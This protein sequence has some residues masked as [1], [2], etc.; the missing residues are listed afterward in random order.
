MNPYPNTCIWLINGSKQIECLGRQRLWYSLIVVVVVE[1]LARL[2]VMQKI[3]VR[4]Y[5]E[6]ESSTTSG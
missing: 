2:P 6:R 3:G 1:W 4:F 5:L